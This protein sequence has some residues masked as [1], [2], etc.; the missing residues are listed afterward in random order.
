MTSSQ[1]TAILAD[2]CFWRM[3]DL[4][5]RYPGVIFTRVGYTGGD[6]QNATYCNHGTHAE[7]WKY[8]RPS[9]AELSEAA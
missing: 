1:E 3:Q 8:L 9:E 6:V 5:R 4:L 2:G 7:R